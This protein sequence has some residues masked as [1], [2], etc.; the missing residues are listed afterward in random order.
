VSRSGGQAIVEMAFIM[1]VMLIIV[2]GSIEVGR[3]F[4]FGVAVQDAARQATRLAAN[5]R[6]DPGVTD[7]GIVQRAIDAAGPA[8][9]GCSLPA[10]VTSTPVSFSCGGGSWT[11]TT[12]VTPNGS[13]SSYNSFGNIPSASLGQLNGGTVEVKVA[14]SVSLLAGLATGW[15]GLALYQIGVQGDAV[16]VVL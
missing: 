14:G 1:P 2:L 8:M 3:A 4:V 5:A 16:M 7:T 6:V 13:A 11:I 12:A 10:S 9:V 15:N